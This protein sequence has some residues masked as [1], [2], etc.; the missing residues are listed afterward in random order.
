MAEHKRQRRGGDDRRGK[1]SDRQGFTAFNMDD[2]NEEGHFD[3]DGNFIWKKEEKS[4][5]EEAWLD[6]LSEEQVE[7]A[8]AAKDRRDYRDEQ[9]DDNRMT[10]ELA[11]Q[12]LATLLQSRETVLQALQRLG[13]KRPKAKAAKRKQPG[14]EP[15]P[16]QTTEE[17]EQFE[18]ITE[19]ADFLMRMGEVDVYGQMKEEFIPEEELLAQRQAQREMQRTSEQ[20]RTVYFSS[21]QQI[22]PPPTTAK[23]ETMW[24]YKGADGQVHGPFPTSTLVAWRQ[25]GYFVG[26]SAVDMRV[27]SSGQEEE[28]QM[29]TAAEAKPALSAEEEL[30]NDFEDSDEDEK[31]EKKPT[32]NG[33]S[34][35]GEN[36]W[37][38]SDAIDFGAY[39]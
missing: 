6:G 24:E 1:R 3:E 4:V 25:Q 7:A 22:I 10:E 15:P 17:K 34:S 26:D 36:A 33:T 37:Q 9:D 5:Q 23:E 38:R 18:R 21:E 16:V 19:A 14:D 28:K 27:V 35:T 32:A 8:K 20:P 13:K 30:M 31:E 29:D 39:Q 2:E 11:N 12:T